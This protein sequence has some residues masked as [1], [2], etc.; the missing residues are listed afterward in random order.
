[1]PGQGFKYLT[2]ARGL[3]VPR[4]EDSE[5]MKQDSDELCGLTTMKGVAMYCTFYA[6]FL[7][8]QLGTAN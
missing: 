6:V 5:T 8:L 7:P 4:A 1:M 2:R 3:L